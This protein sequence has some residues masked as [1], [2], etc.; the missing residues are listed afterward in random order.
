[1]DIFSGSGTTC[2]VSN[3]MNRKFIG[4]EKSNEYYN[5]SINRINNIEIKKLN[6]EQQKSVDCK[7]VLF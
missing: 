2:H 3:V 7:V 4:F 1:M 6:K 5:M